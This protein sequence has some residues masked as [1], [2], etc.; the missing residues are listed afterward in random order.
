MG[1]NRGDNRGR[2]IQKVSRPGRG[3]GQSVVVGGGW[4]RGGG[5]PLGN[6][7]SGFPPE[8][9]LGFTCFLVASEST[10]ISHLLHIILGKNNAW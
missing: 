8:K 3:G 9:I 1:D 4:P 7:G 10:G 2:G 6:G 5:A